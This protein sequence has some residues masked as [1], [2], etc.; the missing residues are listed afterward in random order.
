MTFSLRLAVYLPPSLGFSLGLAVS[1]SR[2]GGM[3][4]DIQSFSFINEVAC[5]RSVSYDCS[6]S[7]W[8]NWTESET[9][10]VSREF[11]VFEDEI[12]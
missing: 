2:N 9:P 4:G 7:W 8:W 6:M 11:M 12:S 10:F 5:S 3:G 1:S